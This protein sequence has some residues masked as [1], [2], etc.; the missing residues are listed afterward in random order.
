MLRI[1]NEIVSFQH[2]YFLEGDITQLKPMILKTIAEKLDMDL[3]TVSRITCN[4]YAHTEFGAVLLKD[5]FTVGIV[6]DQGKEV[7]SRVIQKVIKN[8]VDSENKATP[9]TD[10]Q[11]AA[12]LVGKGF[13]IARRTVSKYREVMRIPVAQQRLA[14]G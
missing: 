13:F 12:L 8:A 5:L 14:W 10:H 2:A 11:L 6:G 9:F 3:S 7:S 1:M 4:K